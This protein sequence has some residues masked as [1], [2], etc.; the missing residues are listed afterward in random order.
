MQAILIT[1]ATGSLGSQILLRAC[2][3]GRDVICLVRAADRESAMARI[4][5]FFRDDL[6]VDVVAGDVTQPL[7]GISPPDISSLRGR[8]GIILHSAASVDFTDAHKAE[9]TNIAGV[10]HV[11]ALAD[12]IGVCDFRHV[13]TAY[14]A[15]NAPH[16]AETDFNKGQSWRNC[17]EQSKHTGERLIRSWAAADA[18][19]RYTIFRPSV[20]IGSGENDLPSVDPYFNG[21]KPLAL[22]AQKLRQI[23]PEKLPEGV[24]V[25]Q[26]GVVTLPV[27]I[28]IPPSATINLVPIG[29]AADRIVT[30][31]KFE[32]QNRTFHL[33]HPRATNVSWLWTTTMRALRIEGARIAGSVEEREELVA[34]LPP[35][36]AR[37]QMLIESAVAAYMPY[38]IGNNIFSDALTRE[39]MRAAYWAPPEI[40]ESYIERLL[41]R[42][43]QARSIRPAN[44][45]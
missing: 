33:V 11:L 36:L 40:E 23:P 26:D 1:G 37:M 7:C 31:V 25:S 45:P 42:V 12:A 5:P 19:R 38:T 32:A 20:L 27:V 8:V 16:F 6:N 41:T 9:A 15:G 29:W 14:V 28:H 30:L 34:A 22:V 3:L 17:Y 2:A 35:A 39:A 13:S 21:F 18:N 43:I 44:L 10:R 4:Q 24:T